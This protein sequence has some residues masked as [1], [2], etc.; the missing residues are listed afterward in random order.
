MRRGE[1]R[2][3]AT[4]RHGDTA[5][6]AEC[7]D[8]IDSFS[9]R[10]RVS[11]SPRL[12]F[13]VSTSRGFTLI[14]LVVTLS[15]LTILTLGVIP[16]V[17]LSVKRQ[18]EER[19]RETLREMRAAIDQFHRDTIGMPCAGAALAQG[20]GGQGQGG[21][22]QGG[23]QGYL[24]PRSTVRIADCTIFGVDNP[25]HYPPD[26]DTLVKG[27]SVEPRVPTI[28]LGGTEAPAPTDNTLLATKKK[29]YLREI[30]IDP[31]TGEQDW[32]LCSTYDSCEPSASWGQE[33]VFNV[34]STSRE[35]ALNGEKYSDW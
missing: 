33:N 17:K 25:D 35:T 28:P 2:D 14:E 7:A 3:A 32:Q 23:Q 24:D 15:I 6:K 27:V 20:Q 19:L 5:R 11:A 4:R 1:R 31:M 16:L 34:R 10:L 18:R 30:P 13:R 22:G 8:A 21:Q 29:V 26:L 12:F 9:P